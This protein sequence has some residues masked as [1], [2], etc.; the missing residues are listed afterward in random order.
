[1]GMCSVVGYVGQNRGWEFVR[2]A[3]GRLECRGY[4]AA[5]F[6]CIDFSTKQLTSIHVAGALHNLIEKIDV[7]RIDGSPSLGYTRWITRD[8][9]IQTTTQ[10]SI[11]GVGRVAV[12]CSGTIEN[13]YALR[14]RMPSRLSGALQQ[15]EADIITHFLTQTID[16]HPSLQKAISELLTN[17]KA[18]MRLSR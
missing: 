13:C 15:V 16:Q 1:M 8:C 7:A 2:D 5:G 14:A 4:D 10:A 11:G 9:D 12:A 6:S 18:L 17:L 3:L